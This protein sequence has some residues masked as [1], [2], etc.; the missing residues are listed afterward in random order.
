MDCAITAS[1]LSDVQNNTALASKQSAEKFSKNESD[2]SFANYLQKERESQK[3]A[4]NSSKTEDLKKSKDSNDA[5]K[6]EESTK[7][8]DDVQNSDYEKT[9]T[10]N[11]K[12]TI[13]NSDSNTS[14]SNEKQVP[15]EKLT[16]LN[17]TN[18][19]DTKESIQ[20]DKKDMS[21]L[22]Q[23]KK[24]SKTESK[25]SS[26]S[27]KTTVSK[28]SNTLEQ[29]VTSDSDKA[30]LTEIGKK[31]S[32]NTED[33]KNKKETKTTESANDQLAV[34]GNSS[35]VAAKTLNTAESLIASSQNINV[36]KKL[37]KESSK[38]D[39]I[40]KVVDERSVSV[41]SQDSA[42]DKIV[43]RVKTDDNGNAQMTMNFT[44]NN[45][46]QATSEQ[47]VTDVATPNSFSQMLDNQLQTNT[48]EF[49][50]AGTIALKDNNQGTINLILHPDDLGNVKIN[51][52]ISDN[53]LKGKIVV[54]SKEA[55]NAFQNNLTNLKQA[56][57]ANGF[58]SASFNV[59]WSGSGAEQSFGG[60]QNNSQSE[61]NPFAHYYE[62]TL[63][64]DDSE[65][66]LRINGSY[67]NIDRKYIDIT[68]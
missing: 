33:I 13:D 34:S 17:L 56:F 21:D 49:V 10:Q 32:V 16:N 5:S 7:K 36:D 66:S 45:G 2:T 12:D 64:E 25:D 31:L 4:E 46:S 67:N 20:S 22:V 23:T 26:L 57:T 28:K 42:S 11:N 27:D 54:A 9:A 59:T 44:G 6:T 1:K 30:L 63:T 55:Y 68:A 40:I 19:T 15:T 51:L 41:N 43:T 60:G 48:Q 18:K 37:T 39:S 52:E 62:D 58:D 47:V 35:T 29:L 38:E 65:E 8:S 24:T 53:V 50:K 61:R 3:Q 14:S